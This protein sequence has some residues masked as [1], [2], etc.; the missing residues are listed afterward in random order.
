MSVKRSLAAIG[1]FVLAVPG[2]ASAQFFFR[3]PDLRDETARGDEP[4]LGIALPGAT[5]AENQASLVWNLRAALNVAALQC[6]FAPTLL[7][8]RNYNAILKDHQVELKKSF[9]TL[10][11]YFVRMKKNNK[12]AGQDALDQFGTRVYSSYSTVGG[13]YTFC[14]AA[15]SISRDAIFANRGGLLALGQARIREL[16]KSLMT[17]GE[18]RFAGYD[19][20][21]GWL[22]LLPSTDKRCWKGNSWN[23]KCGDPYPSPVAVAA[24]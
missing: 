20:R 2:P 7:T 13:Q 23:G 17:A 3:A 10:T 9:D 19:Y 8:T 14:L 16:R 22:G 4:G 21:R 11:K 18:Q 5:E 12:K 6:D 1:L 15:H 24:R